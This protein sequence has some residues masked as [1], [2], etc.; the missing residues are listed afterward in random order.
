MKQIR[1]VFVNPPIPIRSHDW[2]ATFDGYEPGDV[3]GYGE[4]ELAAIDDLMEQDSERR[5]YEATLAELRVK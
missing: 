1:T 5:D 3:I 2:C 4:T